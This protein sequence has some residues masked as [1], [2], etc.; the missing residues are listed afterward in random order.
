MLG[1]GLGRRIGLG[2][3]L[4]WMRLAF[5]LEWMGLELG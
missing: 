4:G 5:E 1:F 3:E 2:L